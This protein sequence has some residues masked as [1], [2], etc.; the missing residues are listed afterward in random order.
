MMNACHT[1][2]IDVTPRCLAV[3]PDAGEDPAGALVLVE[4]LTR[5]QVSHQLRVLGTAPQAGDARVMGLCLLDAPPQGH[6]L[7]DGWPDHEEDDCQRDQPHH[8]RYDY[9]HFHPPIIAL[10]SGTAG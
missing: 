6:V 4:V 1:S 8:D 2:C 10:R 9:A 5:Q 3:F 7:P